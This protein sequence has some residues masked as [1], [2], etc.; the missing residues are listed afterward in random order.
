M[1]PAA[2]PSSEKTLCKA[3]PKTKD[4][5]VGSRVN[6]LRPQLAE[7]WTLDA[8]FYGTAQDGNLINSSLSGMTTQ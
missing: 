1:E 2:P 8:D 4:S 3:S 6:T 5:R 7:P